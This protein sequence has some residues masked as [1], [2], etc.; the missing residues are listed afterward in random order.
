[1]FYFAKDVVLIAGVLAFG[2]RR[3]VM[4]ASSRLFRGFLPVLL[5]AVGWTVL[6]M[7]N[8]DQQSL[9][10]ALLGFR[11]Y[12]L[13]WIAPL[14]VASVIEY[15]SDAARAMMTL[16]VF[17]SIIAAFAIVQFSLPAGHALNGY[18][19][20]GPDMVI[21]TVATTGRARVTATFSYISG[22]TDFITIVPALL[23]SVGLA[24]RSGSRRMVLIGATVLSAIAMPASG[25]RA[26]VLLCLASLAIVASAAG[27]LWTRAG[28]RV[29]LAGGLAITAVLLFAGDALQG[30]QD[31]FTDDPEESR[32]RIVEMIGYLPPFAMGFVEYPALGLAP[33]PFRTRQSSFGSYT[34]LRRRGRAAPRSHRAGR[35][36]VPASLIPSDWSRCRPVSCGDDA[37]ASRRRAA[38]G[39]AWALGA[40]TL[41]G[42]LFFDHIFQALYFL[43]VGIVLQSVV[44]TRSRL[45]KRTRRVPRV[46]IS[47]PHAA[48]VASGVARALRS[49]RSARV[50]RHR[51]SPPPRAPSPRGCWN[52]DL[53]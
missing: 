17:A 36:W 51:A 19:A 6:E 25:S 2:I 28:R 9:A 48:A 45:A 47:H 18:A 20:T 29:L 40:L 3:H 44:R 10:L 13:W 32:S 23:L 21:A 24:T 50:L 34:T 1:M 42:N 22:F 52:S 35:P 15:E 31:R 27:F 43:A 46:L 30:V 38:A 49:D 26:P 8:P 14:V 33:G 11:S 4:G 53:V 7:I 37:E 41:P 12:W 39:A 5:L 16:G